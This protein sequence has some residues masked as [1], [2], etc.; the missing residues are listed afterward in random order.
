MSVSQKSSLHPHTSST[1]QIPF[2]AIFLN[3]LL[4]STLNLL[5]NL[6]HT[7]EQFEDVQKIFFDGEN[8]DIELETIMR[9]ETSN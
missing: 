2:H 3:V 1:S 4:Q 6:T 8:C 9:H 5:F 7:L